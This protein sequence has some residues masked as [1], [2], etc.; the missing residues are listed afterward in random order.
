MAHF[1]RKEG[2]RPSRVNALLN[3]YEL[4]V[5]IQL[6]YCESPPGLSPL[7][8]VFTSRPPVQ[9][10]EPIATVYAPL[11]YVQQVFTALRT[12]KFLS[13][14]NS[15]DPSNIW[16]LFLHDILYSIQTNTMREPF[17]FTL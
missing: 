9:A 10:P 7:E 15:P 11:R 14:L 17:Q 12:L 1:S 13:A 16:E 3:S 8:R 5:H 6:F 2:G 4:R